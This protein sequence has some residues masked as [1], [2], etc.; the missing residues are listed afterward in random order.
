M[1]INGLEI[2]IN[3]IE[4]E[5]M[6]NEQFEDIFVFCGP[7]VVLKLLS[8][9]GGCTIKVPRNG[10]KKIE[11]KM[12]LKEFDNTAIG[13]QRLARKYKTTEQNIRNILSRSR[14]TFPS[15]GQR[16]LFSPEEF[17]EREKDG[18]DN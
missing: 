10:F 13:I 11:R 3:N 9:F 4:K 7:E 17:M 12:I 18:T 14:V 1:R 16:Q 8:E 5:D 2:D 6:P 15:E